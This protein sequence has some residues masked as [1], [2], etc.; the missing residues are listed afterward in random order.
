[1][2]A[3]LVQRDGPAT[4]L[5]I[6]RPERD[7][8][9]TAADV[10]ELADRLETAAAD[11]ATRVVVLAGAGGTLCT[12]MDLAEVAGGADAGGGSGFFDLLRRI[13]EIDVTVVAAL[14]GRAVG[15]GVG[16]AAAC[17][18]VVATERSAFSLPEALW[19]LLPCNILPFLI[20]RTGFQRAYAMTLSTATMTAAEARTAGLVDE[21]DTAQGRHLRR[22]VGRLAKV[23]RATVGEAKAYCATLSPIGADTRE[24]ASATFARLLR[25]PAVHTRID[26]YVR[27]QR[28]PWEQ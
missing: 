9:L 4:R 10:R 3:V 25:T 12:G 5:V 14:D 17:D 21:L 13:T 22:L 18:L 24:H 11:P 7:N 20:R 1:M 15:G 2:G 26:N 16:L 23:D 28:M 27:H 8:S 19:G 6:D